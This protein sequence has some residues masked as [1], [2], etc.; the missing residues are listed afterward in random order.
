MGATTLLRGRLLAQRAQVIFTRERKKEVKK[1]GKEKSSRVEMNR[2]VHRPPCML[3]CLVLYFRHFRFAS[4]HDE[5][6]SSKRANQRLH[7]KQDP[8]SETS[9][10]S[11]HFRPVRV[12]P[13]HKI[14][15]NPAVRVI[16][17]GSRISGLL[18]TADPREDD[19]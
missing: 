11:Q 19:E 7:N 17:F 1:G 12:R 4:R 14:S 16:N 10:I 18:P 13:R 15:Q 2:R 3:A 9:I 5:I 6:M 8:E